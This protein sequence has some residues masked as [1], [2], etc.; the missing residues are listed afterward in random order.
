MFKFLI[1][2]LYGLFL[3]CEIVDEDLRLFF[4]K[5]LEKELEIF[6]KMLDYGSVVEESDEEEEDVVE[7]NVELGMDQL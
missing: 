6:Y 4:I 7:I 5:W 2:E 3:S 1:N